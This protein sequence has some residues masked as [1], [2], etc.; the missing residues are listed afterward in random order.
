[1]IHMEKR[2]SELEK[3]NKELLEERKQDKEQLHELQVLTD[4]LRG[5][6]RNQQYVNIKLSD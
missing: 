6:L 4:R 3:Q 2:L 5:D 1:M